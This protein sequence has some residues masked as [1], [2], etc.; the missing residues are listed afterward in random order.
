LQAGILS[1]FIMPGQP[2]Y[3]LLLVLCVVFNCC[4]PSTHSTSSPLA[5]PETGTLLYHPFNS[6]ADIKPLIDAIGN[7]RIVLIGEST[8]GTD[9]FYKW[10]TA[11][12]KQLVS[13]KGFNLISIEGDWTDTRRMNLLLRDGIADSAEIFRALKK[14]DRWPEVMWSNEEMLPLFNWINGENRNNHKIDIYGLDVYSFWEWMND[15]TIHADPDVM[16]AIYQA[17]QFYD[18]FNGDAML[19]GAAGATHSQGNAIVNKLGNLITSRWTKKFPTMEDDFILYQQALLTMTGEH[20][21]SIMRDDHLTAIDLRDQFMAETVQRL[22]NYHGKNAKMIVWVHNGHAGDDRYSG[23]GGSGYHSTAEILKKSFGNENVFSIGMGTYK[24][25]VLAAYRWNSDEIEQVV[26]PAK[27]DSW[28]YLLHKIN[29]EN[30]LILSKEIIKGSMFDQ[31]MEFRAIGATFDGGAIYS[32][33]LMS[34]RFDAF[35][36]VDSTT[37]I[38]PI[39]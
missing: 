24:G 36:F 1:F 5:S 22:L 31:W 23:Y 38:H 12:T 16:N 25:K 8:H 15:S 13:Q 20:Y 6:D 21:F 34:K 11:I 3:V 17:K 19:Y 29:N 9:E 10:R 4:N 35:V 18:R 30:K 33:S 37:A 27:Q 26:L 28:E 7:A 14:Y 2:L 32:K 39:N